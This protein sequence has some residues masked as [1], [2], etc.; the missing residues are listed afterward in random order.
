[1][2]T[3][4]TTDLI[5]A[6]T[7]CNGCNCYFKGSHGLSNHFQ[8]NK[9]CKAIHLNLQ[10]QYQL[11]K[12]VHTKVNIDSKI[13]AVTEL[14]KLTTNQCP[15]KHESND[16]CN[17]HEERTIEDSSI[18]TN[19]F[20]SLPTEADTAIEPMNAFTYTNDIRVEN[21]LLKLVSDMNAT[22]DAFKKIIDWAKDASSTGY[23]FNPENTSY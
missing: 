6:Q 23:Q 21:N 17:M 5:M 12:N 9:E 15:V 8:Y 7:K 18:T 11:S 16:R 1:M 2:P 10:H 14:H 19:P 20:A 3:F 13:R 4:L 22:N